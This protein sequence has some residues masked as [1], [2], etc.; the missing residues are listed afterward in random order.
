MTITLTH[1]L[2]GQLEVMPIERDGTREWVCPNRPMLRPMQD[3][4]F[5]EKRAEIDAMLQQAGVK[6]SDNWMSLQ[7]V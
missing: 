7:S 1:F 3:C 2:R 6:P 4:D 5:T